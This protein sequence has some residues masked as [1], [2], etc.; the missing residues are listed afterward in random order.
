MKKI[1][2]SISR[3][4]EDY[5]ADFQQIY[6]FVSNLQGAIERKFGTLLNVLE[7]SVQ[8]SIQYLE[9]AIE[10]SHYDL[11][12]DINL[13]AFQTTMNE[14][15]KDSYAIQSL[16]D[17]FMTDKITWMNLA[18]SYNGDCTDASD[19]RQ[20]CIDRRNKPDRPCR[21]FIQNSKN[22]SCTKTIESFLRLLNSVNSFDITNGSIL[23]FRENSKQY[24]DIANR[25][26]TC[27]GDYFTMVRNVSVDLQKVKPESFDKEVEDLQLDA[28]TSELRTMYAP[29]YQDQRMIE[30]II[31]SYKSG[32]MTKN[33]IV[34]QLAGNQMAGITSRIER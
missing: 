11:T 29:L 30:E 14:I 19:P 2:E 8:R 1:D 9:T 15:R 24:L 16:L 22:D 28:S 12:L 25:V 21:L 23:S 18:G 13:K 27:Y 17:G 4:R 31:R 33:D 10:V 26:Q 5:E 34:E 20:C 3:Y 32:R 6:E 7:L